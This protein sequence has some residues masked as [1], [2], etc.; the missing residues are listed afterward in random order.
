MLS[1]MLLAVWAILAAGLATHFS[2]ARTFALFMASAALIYYP[3]LVVL[4]FS[5]WPPALVE[6]AAHAAGWGALVWFVRLSVRHFPP[7][8]QQQ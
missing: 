4:S 1:L 6:I 5:S 3:T 7:Q 8:Q 2:I